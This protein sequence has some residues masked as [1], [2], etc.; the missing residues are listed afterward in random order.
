MRK[1]AKSKV[2]AEESGPAKVLQSAFRTFA[3][4][5]SQAAESRAQL[6]GLRVAT[7]PQMDRFVA[8]H[9][10]SRVEFVLRIDRE[11]A[12]ASATI[13]CFRMDSA[14][15]SEEATIARLRYGEAGAV[16]EAS[17][18]ELVGERIDQSPGASSIIAGRRPA[19]A[20]QGSKGRWHWRYGFPATAAG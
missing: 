8:V 3:K 10:N 14:G 2:T 1:A 13:D 5:A 15:V 12:E 18:P 4:L 7:D 11:S 6:R 20:R 19:R 17:I 16:L 9:L